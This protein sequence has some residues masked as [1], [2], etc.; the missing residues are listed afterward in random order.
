MSKAAR[1]CSACWCHD[2]RSRRSESSAMSESASPAVLGFFQ[3]LSRAPRLLTLAIVRLL[4]P[5]LVVVRV[6]WDSSEGLDELLRA[7][8]A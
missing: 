1:C 3:S 8:D 4:R 6:A 2:L 5:E 7:V